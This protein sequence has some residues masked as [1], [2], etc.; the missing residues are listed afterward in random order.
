MVLSR[1][2][3]ARIREVLKKHPEGISITDL[4]KSVDVN[5]NTAGRYLENMLL[6]GQVEMRRFGMAKLYT[7][8][9][10]LPVSSVL[11]ISSELVMQLDVSQRVFYANDPLLTFIGVQAQDLFGKNIEFTP[12][13]IVF[14]DIFSDLLDRF[15]RG[16]KAE[17]WRGELS[18]PVRGR[19]FFCR[20]APT[21]FSEGTKGVLVIL[22]DISEQKRDEE[23]IRKS[24]ARLRSIFKASPVGIGV[25]S[26]RVLLEVNDR[27]CQMTGYTAGELIGKSV[28]LLY[29]TQE[30]YDR[31]GMRRYNQ[32][33]QTWTGSIET[34]WIKK[35]GT[36]IDILLSSTPLDP[37][38]IS[39]GL[40]F[41]AMDITEH[42]QAEQELR[43]SEDRYRKLVEISPDAVFLHQDGKVIYVNP[44]AV[45]L[46]KEGG[47]EDLLGRNIL[48]L[49]EPSSRGAVLT[50]IAKDI[51]GE[52]TP[53]MELKMIRADGTPVIV[54]GRG[55][56][57]SIMGKQTVLV[58]V[59]DI[60][61]RYRA[62]QELR[63]SESTARALLNAPTDSVVLV[64][65]S[66]IILD[67]N[68]TAATSLGKKRE[69]LIGI[70]AD[71]V[72]SSDIAQE[73]RRKIS[74]VFTTR[75]P[76]RFIDERGGTWFDNV[77]YPI[78]DNKGNVSRLAIIARDITDQKKAEQALR[79]SE[80]RYRSLAEASQDL[81]F[82]INREDR[83]EYV[84]SYAAAILKIP[85]DQVIGEKRSVLFQ[86]TPGQRQAQALRRVFETGKAGRSEGAIEIFGSLHWFDH[87]LIPITDPHG[88]VTSVLGVSRDI[89]DRKEA[90][91]ALRASEERYRCLLEQTFD[92]VAIH[93]NGKIATLNERAAR[94]L[95]AATPQELVGR[96][97]FDL[98]HPDSRRDLEERIGML[99][100]DTSRPVP[101]LREKFFRVD[102]T[103]VTVDV[104]AIRISDNG[105]PAI[106][107]MFREITSPE[108]QY[109]GAR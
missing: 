52:M 105:L 15:R 84:N 8:T 45:R 29:R 79:E 55:V 86:G 69:D 80:D 16:L 6:S 42:N 17:E 102:G 106:Q 109:P 21:V 49:I 74:E 28:R 67:L 95:G 63:E 77:A 9:K 91:D 4:V 104:M 82:L 87:Y 10:R 5:R 30:E 26:G 14:E 27:F 51:S 85:A 32:V 75:Q 43:E 54:E 33:Q 81:I 36:V 92:A 60:T 73:R 101:V 35:D 40:T 13:A 11:S 72:L 50:N 56:G 65:R 90:E 12:F 34:Q 96:P 1:E 23:R 103:T 94:I 107:V 97:I 44:A 98:I 20:V 38:N 100:A 93:K 39:S 41:T 70:L 61:D 25:V 57:T 2:I 47:E 83:V 108:P 3:T 53:R 89:T 31:V 59:N 88:F 99:V 66:G 71:N 58:A 62:E 7:L 18:R 46:L 64:D 19:Y 48:D 37:A 78:L 24:E 68:E 22:E 76:V